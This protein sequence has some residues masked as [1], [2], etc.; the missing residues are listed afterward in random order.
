MILQMTGSCV[1]MLSFITHDNK[2]YAWKSIGEKLMLFE[3]LK[4]IRGMKSF[5]FDRK[6]EILNLFKY[7][8]CQKS[9]KSLRVTKFFF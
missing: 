9:I 8:K 3:W 2:Q 5:A 1:S 7:G 4:I 6:N